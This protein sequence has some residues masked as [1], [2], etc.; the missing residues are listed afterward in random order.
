MAQEDSDLGWTG[1]LLVAELI[2]EV[3]A[4]RSFTDA[5]GK[6]LAK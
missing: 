6:A 2:D 5:L 3:R 4:I 1:A